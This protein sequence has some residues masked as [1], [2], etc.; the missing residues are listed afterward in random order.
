MRISRLLRQARDHVG[1]TVIFVAFAA[2]VL[3]GMAALAVD[4]GYLYMVRGELQNAADSGALAGAQVLY[5]N[6]GTSV[7]PSAIDIAHQYATSHLSERVTVTAEDDPVTTD[8]DESIKIGH[9]SFATHTFS[10]IEPPYPAP[11]N[12]WDVTTAEL[13]ADPQFVN[14]VRVI[15]RRKRDASGQVPDNFFAKVLGAARSEVK[16]SA[17]APA[18]PATILSLYI[19]RTFFA[20]CLRMVLPSVTWPSPPIATLPSLLTHSMVVPC[21]ISAP[22][23]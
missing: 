1:A 18:K 13:D 4:L 9:W 23:R 16:A 5:N 14:A 11:P 8:V 15:T 20:L 6:S 10:P 21:I 17:V 2:V 3:F 22:F 7:N 12:L 19:L